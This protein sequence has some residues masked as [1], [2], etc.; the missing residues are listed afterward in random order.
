[1]DIRKKLEREVFARS[2][3]MMVSG[4]SRRV[5]RDHHVLPTGIHSHYRYFLQV[6]V[7]I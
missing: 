5:C 1:M 3:G 4:V 2:D 7:I 6:T